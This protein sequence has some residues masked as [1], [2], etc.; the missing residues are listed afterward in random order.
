VIASLTQDAFWCIDAAWLA[1][2]IVWMV[3]APRVKPT[4][5]RES[6]A[7]RAAHLVPLVL[8]G[9]LLFF[10]PPGDGWWTC[11]EVLPRGVWMA[12]AGLCVVLAGL[13]FA[14]RARVVLARNWSGIVTIKQDHE[15]IRTGPYGIVRHPIYTGLLTALLGTA[16]AI[17][18]WRGVLS[19]AIVA[20][21]FL[22]KMRTE[23][24]FMGRAF[25]EAYSRYRREV[26]GL[27]PW[28]GK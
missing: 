17:D 10:C 2:L 23:E 7:R 1:W 5:M 26:P 3:L 11:L 27:I 25:G 6:V 8:A 18:Q 14:V 28:T 13:G 9:A 16:I 15:L 22:A 20:V 12:P 4:A 21:S 19:L 24:A